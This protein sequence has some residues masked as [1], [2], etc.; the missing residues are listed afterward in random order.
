MEHKGINQANAGNVSIRSKDGFFITPSGIPYDQLQDQDIVFVHMDG[1]TESKLKP[2][3]EWRMHRDIYQHFPMA[4]AVLHAHPTYAT[5]LS[6]LRLDIPAFH[7]MIA[8]AGGHDIKCTDY[9]LFGTEDL[10]NAMLKALHQRKAC[11]LG[12]HGMICY[13]DSLDRVLQL[14]VEIESLAH[15][16]WVARQIGEPELLTRDEMQQVLEKFQSYGNQTASDD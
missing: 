9:A 8:V 15:Q 1:R 7:Y 10:S 16:Y 11:L 4:H 2:S 12:T 6:C 3:S 14:G 5:A 13:H